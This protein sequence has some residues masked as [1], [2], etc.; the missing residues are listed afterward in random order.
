MPAKWNV[1]PGREETALMM[2]AGCILRDA[3]RFQCEAREV[4]AGVRALQPS[5][6][7]RRI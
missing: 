4:F 6:E 2:E 7:G 1:A 5:N 3:R